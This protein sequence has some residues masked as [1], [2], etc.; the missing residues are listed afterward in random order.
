M[1]LPWAVEPDER[2]DPV[3]QVKPA[4]SKLV[5][6]PAAAAPLAAAEPLAA[7]D[8]PADVVVV[9]LSL[10]QAANTRAPAVS[11]AARPARRAIFTPFLRHVI[12]HVRRVLATMRGAGPDERDGRG[13]DGTE[14][15]RQV[16]AR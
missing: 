12:A 6:P 10:P 2:S 4:P 9:L 14:S 3:A 16:N 5:P 11:S 8:P 7:A 15:A 1:T 13:R